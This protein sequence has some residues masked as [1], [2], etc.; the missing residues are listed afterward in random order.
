MPDTTIGILE[1]ELKNKLNLYPNP[2][3]EQFYVAYSGQKQLQFQLYNLMGQ[4]VEAA[5]WKEGNRYRFSSGH[6]LKG[7]YLLRVRDGVR[8]EM[9]K[10]VKD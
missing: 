1:N 3:G 5:V 2:V 10:I 8:D 4:I 9:L 6:L 7:V